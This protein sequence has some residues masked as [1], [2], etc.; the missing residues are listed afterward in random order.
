[1]VRFGREEWDW[2]D[3]TGFLRHEDAIDLGEVR[4]NV[5]LSLHAFG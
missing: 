2:I 1:M 5:D 3:F 4:G